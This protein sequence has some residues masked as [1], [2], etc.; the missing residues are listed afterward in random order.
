MLFV[1]PIQKMRQ[2]SSRLRDT[3][4]SLNHIS[5]REASSIRPF[6]INV[7][8]V[9]AGDTVRSFVRQMAVADFKEETFRILNGLGATAGLRTGQLVKI[10]ANK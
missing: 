6:R 9:H 5:N 10:V 3:V 4:F 2:L 8:A 1:T 7:K